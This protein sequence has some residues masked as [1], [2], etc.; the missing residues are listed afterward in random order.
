MSRGKG[1][2]GDNEALSLI[3]AGVMARRKNPAAVALGRRGGKKKVAKGLATMDKR[4]ANRIRRAGAAARWENWRKQNPEK[5]AEAAER[6]SK[7]M[8]TTQ[9]G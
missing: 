3:M 8:P 9:D 6:K 7:R 4:L 2:W 1:T 5:A